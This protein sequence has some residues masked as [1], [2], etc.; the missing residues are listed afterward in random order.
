MSQEPQSHQGLN[1]D[2]VLVAINEAVEEHL[3]HYEGPRSQEEDKRELEIL[4]RQGTEITHTDLDSGSGIYGDVVK[5][6]LHLI[7]QNKR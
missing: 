4:A 2:E 3:R 5:Q 7:I 1:W 6:L